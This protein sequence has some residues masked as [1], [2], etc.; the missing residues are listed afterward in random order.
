MA[1]EGRERKKSAIIRRMLRWI[2]LGALSLLLIT[3]IIFQA[4]WKVIALLLIFLLAC[5]AL[6]RP[7]R[8]WF[9]LSVGVIIMALI[10]WVFL[11]EDNEGWHP[12][13]FNEELAALQAKYAIPDSEN[14]AII[15]D[16]LLDSYD[17]GTFLWPD[18]LDWELE[19][20]TISGPWLSSEYPELA[21]WLQGQDGKIKILMQ[22]SKKNKCRFPIAGDLVQLTANPPRDFKEVTDF[23]WSLPH[24]RP[25]PMRELGKLLVRVANNDIAE[26][27]VDEA[28]EK[29]IAVLQIGGHLRQQPSILDIL[30]G[31]AVKAMGLE[32]IKA[33]LVSGDATE[34]RLA[35]LQAAL[36]DKED[37]WRSDFLKVLENDKLILKYFMCAM[38]YQTNSENKVR[39]NRDPNSTLRN[40][41]HID[42]GPDGR[43][44]EYW[45][46]KLTKAETIF[47]WFFVPPTPQ[48]AAKIIDKVCDKW[49][50]MAEADFDWQRPP[51]KFFWRSIRSNYRSFAEMMAH[52]Y[53]PAYSVFHNAY[54]RSLVDRRCCWLI[55][56][57]RQYKN[58]NGNWPERLEDI[59]SLVPPE[60]FTDPI[61]GDTFVYKLSG[62]GFTLYSRGKNNI[63]EGGQ[64]WYEKDGTG[65]DD[66][67][68]WPPRNRRTKG[69]KANV[70]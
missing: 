50:A 19:E 17:A 8:K 49:Y 29:Y 13:T 65:P 11:P 53:Q 59:R 61:G 12:Y 66:L 52:I 44:S 1:E 43:L 32:Q 42:P 5:T 22:A 24:R 62:E 3:V 25:V 4:P 35:L 64:K 57:L 38:A 6:P 2:G 18:S 28:L 55:L 69:E 34:G 46:T 68:I 9:W 27:R 21:T 15:Y 7:F 48:K 51:E 45:E 54:L 56:G 33:F 10:I 37:D 30:V 70:E 63:D 40:L 23:W 36:N 47:C 14:A 39:L 67:L 16:Q 31:M 60:V 41:I 26:G 20:L 58:R